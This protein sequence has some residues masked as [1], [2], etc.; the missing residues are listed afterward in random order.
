MN[1]MIW[2]RL[3]WLFNR[4]VG[5]ALSKGL[6]KGL[7]VG[8]ALAAILAGLRL[9][10]IE[11]WQRWM[12]DYAGL[13]LVWRLFL[14]AVIVWGGF[15]LCRRLRQ[16]ERSPEARQRWRY[17]KVAVVISLVLLE[18]SQRLRG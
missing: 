9:G 10:R 1:R 12:A 16:Y 14:Y 18:A 11:D 15:C 7:L 3:P 17:M 6:L 4:R 2:L 5:L 13:F 8:I